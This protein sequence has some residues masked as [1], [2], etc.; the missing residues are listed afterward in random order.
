[1]DNPEVAGV[2]VAFI[3]KVQ[4]Y[5]YTALVGVASGAVDFIQK[6]S[7]GKDPSIKSFLYFSFLACVIAFTTLALVRYLG[8]KEDFVAYMLFFWAGMSQEYLFKAIP[9]LIKKFINKQI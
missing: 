8:M 7:N 4:S 5:I 6:K 2:I 9:E 3:V 1:M